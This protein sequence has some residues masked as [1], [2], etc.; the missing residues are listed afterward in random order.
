MQFLLFGEIQLFLLLS[1]IFVGFLYW[2]N[3]KYKSFNKQ[4]IKAIDIPVYLINKQG[5][6]LKLLNE[7][8]EKANLLPLNNLG[9][10]NL[11]N[12]IITTEEYQ[13]HIALL[14]KVLETRTPESLI[15]KIKV[16]TGEELYVSVRMVYLN[17]ER[18]IAFVRNITESE[19]QRQENEKYRYFLESILENLPIA[20]TVKDNNNKGLYLI[21][22]KKASEMV[23]ISS[24]KIIGHPESEFNHL[25]PDNF[26]QETDRQVA[27]TGLPQSYIKV[28]S[29]PK[30]QKHTLSFHK[31]L[32]SYNNGQECWI[33]SS[34]L[35]I[36]ELLEAKE[37]AEESNRLK[38]AFLA[39]MSHEIRTPLNAIVGFSSILS[40]YIQNE[41]MKEYV[42]I[43]EENNQLLLQ[44]INDILDISRIEAGILEFVEGNMNVNDTL[45]EIYT[46]VKLKITSDIDIRFLPGLEQCIIHTI[47]KRVKQVINNYVSNAIKHTP[48][49]YIDI[50]YNVPQEGKIRFF[51]RDT[52]TGIPAEKQKHIF[53]RFVKLDSFKQGTGLGLSICTM[54]AERMNGEIGVNSVQGKGSEFW[55]KIP[56][57]P[58]EAYTLSQ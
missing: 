37:K 6:V 48:K 18:V 24:E 15:V 16:E 11:R 31:T 50:G 41:D 49:G 55:F 52:R 22:N 34:A 5:I 3:R 9:K 29:N 33:V 39:N 8:T 20:T 44:L 53:E 30:G 54:I 14:Q 58:V 46:T 47:P 10:L 12:L 7:P 28:F 35:D 45:H 25:M 23:G 1:V 26:I 2:I 56:Y 57:T 42:H 51:V 32:V 17:R 4:I 43:I 40:E 36:T 38:S 21:W 13:K 27:E 19:N